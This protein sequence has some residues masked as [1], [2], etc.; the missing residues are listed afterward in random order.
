[1]SLFVKWAFRKGEEKRYPN[2]LKIGED[3]VEKC[4]G[5]PLAVRTLG[6]LLYLKTD[7]HDWLYIKDNEIW[8]LEQKENDIL[9]ALRLSYDAMPAYLKQCFAFCSI[10]P[11][12]KDFNNVELTILWMAHCGWHMVSFSHLLKTKSSKILHNDTSKSYG[13]DLSF[14][15]FKRKT[16][17]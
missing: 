11:K 2:L 16:C 6:S 17:S 14:K 7:E 13:R 1:M 8:K 5:V 3:I 12:D 4:G 9:P 10:F 15:I